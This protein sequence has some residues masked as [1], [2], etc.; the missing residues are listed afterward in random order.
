M[1]GTAH[2]FAG[3][4]FVPEYTYTDDVSVLIK[5]NTTIM[6]SSNASRKQR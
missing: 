3:T 6:Q 4:T 1:P 2:A 5:Y